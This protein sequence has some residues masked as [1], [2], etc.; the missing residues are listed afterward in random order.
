MYT[1]SAQIIPAEI[2]CFYGVYR[3]IYEYATTILRH[4]KDQFILSDT[5]KN[6]EKLFSQ[7]GFTLASSGSARPQSQV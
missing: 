4:M 5:A 3:R 7:A 1:C 2:D 6:K